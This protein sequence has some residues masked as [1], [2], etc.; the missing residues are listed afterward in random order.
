M[1]FDVYS[2]QKKSHTCHRHLFIAESYDHSVE[3]AKDDD[4]I[5]N[6]ASVQGQI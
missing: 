2:G 3:V 6:Y 1:F 4:K 5:R